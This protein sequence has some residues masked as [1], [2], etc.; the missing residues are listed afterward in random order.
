M[1]EQTAGPQARVEQ[2]WRGP[3]LP[4]GRWPMA[5]RV[6]NVG[7]QAWEIAEAWLPHGRFRCE[8]QDYT[9]SLVVRSG[10]GVQLEF[11]VRWLEEPGTVVEN[12]FVILRVAL[13]E[14]TWRI[15]ARLTAV[16]D[17][18]GAPNTRTELVTVQRVE[19]SV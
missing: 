5:W 1:A 18:Q 9:P 16:A 12:A 3:Q 14:E 17:D 10:D 6:T 11:P 19:W 15:F 7:D 13:H 8:R 2:I 4:D